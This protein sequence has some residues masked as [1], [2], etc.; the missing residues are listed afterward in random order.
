MIIKRIKIKNIRSYS[1]EEIKFPEGTIMLSGDIGSGKSTILLAVEFALFGIKRGELS[2]NA[3]LRNGSDDGYVILDFNIDNNVFSVK[4]TLKRSVN[5]ISQDSGFLSINDVTQQLTPVELKQRVTQLLNYPLDS[6]SKKSLTYRYTVYTPQEEMKLILLGEKEYRLETLRKVF[7]I[8]KYKRIKENSKIALSEAKQKKKELSLFVSD[9]E[10]KRLLFKE[11]ELKLSSI[12]EN[13]I[14]LNEKL[15]VLNSELA[16]NKNKVLEFEESIK[17]LN[18]T[19]KDFEL[20]NFNIK[21][22]EDSKNKNTFN[23]SQL[24]KQIIELSSNIKEINFEDVKNKI[25][26]HEKHLDDHDKE[27][28]LINNNITSIRTKK[29]SSIEIKNQINK[30]DNCPLCRQV[31]SIDYKNGVI[32]REDDNL[33]KLDNDIKEFLIKESEFI[34]KIKEI[35]VLIQDLKNKERDYEINKIKIKDLESKKETL[36]KLK[37]ENEE[38]DF[39]IKELND[40]KFIIQN[41]IESN[42]ELEN[43][44]VMNKK[45]LEQLLDSQKK[46]ELSIVIN[47]KD[48]DFIE[49]ELMILKSDIENKEKAS[50]KLDYYTKLCDWFDSFFINIIDIIEKKTMSKLH[51]DFSDLFQKWFSML[52]DESVLKVRL[53]EEFT[54]IIE[55]NSHDIEYE[56]LSGGEKTSCALAYRLALNQVINN[57]SNSINTKDLI[58]LDEPT[59]G[60]SEEQ[61]DKIRD[62]IKELKMRQIIIVSHENKV[63]SFV[64]NV[65][66]IKKENHISKV[67][68]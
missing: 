60:F 43:N 20:L 38:L 46:L 11:K 40:K 9:I 36:D 23:L 5:G 54:P 42:K 39:I 49:K 44:Y 35:K 31:V 2:G 26:E 33:L 17:K 52:I 28:K 8:D 64:D 58:I 21:T 4:R 53:D 25:I 37:K 14:L 10:Q 29:I 22:K 61:L 13:I 56:N 59:D 30:L 32:S 34:L 6:I 27:L 65:I 41:D 1:E 24:E 7:N 50:S 15:L 3:L 12:S 68:R 47:N 67:I 66:K 48:K 18:N 45:L 19:K 16:L 62:I 55:Q 63:E 57:I 51:S